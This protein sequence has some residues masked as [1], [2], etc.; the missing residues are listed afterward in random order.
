MA[1]LWLSLGAA[2]A[3]KFTVPLDYSLEKKADFKKYEK[4]ILKCAD[5][6]EKVKTEGERVDVGPAENFLSEWVTAC[7]YLNYTHNVRIDGVFGDVPGLSTYYMAG[8]VRNALSPSPTKPTQLDNCIAGMRCAVEVYR[9][10]H[11]FPRS[12]A[13]GEVVKAEK[14]GTLKEWVADRL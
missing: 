10:N 6:L 13:F 2:T 4:D 3:Q 7:P 8:W 11:S 9:M 1:A 5:W 12:K 14:N